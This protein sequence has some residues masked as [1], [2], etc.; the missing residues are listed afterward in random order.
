V[1]ADLEQLLDAAVKAGVRGLVGPVQLT[2]VERVV[3][4]Q[5]IGRGVELFPLE[6]ARDVRRQERT[7]GKALKR[8][9]AP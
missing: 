3:L 7:V 4:I 9:L 6:E 8:P 5:Q 1:L 2:E